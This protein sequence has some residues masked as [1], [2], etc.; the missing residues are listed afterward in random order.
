MC[1]DAQRGRCA[2]MRRG[3]RCATVSLPEASAPGPAHTSA[4]AM[5]CRS[6]YRGST[7]AARRNSRSG[8]T[9]GNGT[10]GTKVSRTGYGVRRHAACIANRIVNPFLRALLWTAAILLPGGIVLVPVLAG[11]ALMRKAQVRPRTPKT[12]DERA[13]L[14]RTLRA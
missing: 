6:W 4:A 1:V 7:R 12:L 9:C 8:P 2:S 11:E 5:T 13:P 10:A 14:P 3:G